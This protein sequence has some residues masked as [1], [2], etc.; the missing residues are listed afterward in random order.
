MPS[1]AE[2]RD[3]AGFRSKDSAFKL[4]RR[5]ISEGLLA[6][7]E[8]GKLIPGPQFQAVQLLGTIEAGFP[9]PA[10]EELLDTMNLDDYLI[11]NREATFLLNV[12]GKSMIDAGILPGDQVLVE[13]GATAKDGDIVIAEVDGAWTMKYLKKEGRRVVLVP[14]NKAYKPIVPK[15]ELRIAA[16]VRALI[17]KY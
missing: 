7:D 4:A 8:A 6:K 15:S 12:T 11:K 13:R 17:R 10:E 5:L 16:V 3:L 9:S 2:M 14:A 1:Y